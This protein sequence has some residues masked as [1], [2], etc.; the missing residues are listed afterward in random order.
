MLIAVDFDGTI[1]E[2]AYPLIGRPI[3]FAIDVLKKL[4]ED[5]HDIVL[6]TYRTGDMLNEA[7]EYCR[8]KGL[9]FYAVNRMFPEEDFQEGM[10]R[11]IDADIFI[12]DKNLGG[13]PDWGVIY[14]MI[15]YGESEDAAYDNN[16]IKNKMPKKKSFWKRLFGE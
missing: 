15:K 11:K 1:V 16:N 2:H 9:E 8:S 6:W 7:V 12:D 5:G 13:L 4:Q 3:P 14:R 10:P